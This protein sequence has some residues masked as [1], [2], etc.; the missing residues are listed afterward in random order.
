MCLTQLLVYP[1]GRERQWHG[2]RRG[3]ESAIN[4]RFTGVASKLVTGYAALVAMYH[5]L[6]IAGVFTR[7][8]IHIV[9]YSHMGVSLSLIFSLVFLF[10]PAAKQASKD[11]LPWYDALFAVIALLPGAYMLF[12]W[13]LVDIHLE[14]ATMPVY[15]AVIFWWTLIMLFETGRRTVGLVMPILAAF[16]FVY[17]FTAPVFPGFLYGHAFS[18]LRAMGYLFQSYHGVWGVAMSAAAALIFIFIVFARFLMVTG[19]GEFI[20]NFSFSLFGHVRGGPAKVAVV[21]SGLFGSI[22]GGSVINVASTGPFT[23]P[24]MKSIGYE[25]EFA[26]AVEAVASNGGQ[27]MPPIMGIVAFLIAEFLAMPYILVCLAAVVPALL[28]FLALF[29]MVDLEAGRLGLKGL[30]QN[31][32]PPLWPIVKRGWPYVIPPLVLVVFLIVFARTAPVACLYALLVLFVVNLIRREGRMTPGAFIRGLSEGAK[33]MML[34]TPVCALA[35]IIIGS[36]SLSAVGVKLSSQLIEISG[37]NIWLLLLLT[38]GSS[39]ILGMGMT[40]LP[41]YIILVILV[42]PALINMGVLPI[43]A[44]LFVFSWG[45]VSFI[46]PPVALAAW[47]AAGIADANPWKTGWQAV[48]LGIVIYI[49]PFMFVMNPALLLQGEVTE[50]LWVVVTAIT[51]TAALAAAIA[52][53][54][55]RKMTLLE[56]IL[57]LGGSLLLMYPSWHTDIIGFGVLILPVIWQ[58]RA[59]FFSRRPA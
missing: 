12:F 34:I 45:I 53:Y 32:L 3:K 16:F 6:Y 35:G 43:A 26:G 27:I 31:E 44:H 4:R 46:T 18:T 58:L 8:N 15:E 25:P 42:A 57:S 52:G 11:G 41:C 40:S 9:P 24:M 37:G 39:F 30:P 20:T 21:A 50:I 59:F 49:I 38:A 7:M 55:V 14:K 48:R 1:L 5:L 29:I 2:E 17:L 56:R 36:I 23:I 10:R 33:G 13:K 47:V 51:G 22:S 19:A 28:Y 54:A